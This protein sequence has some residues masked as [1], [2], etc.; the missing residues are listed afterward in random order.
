MASNIPLDCSELVQRWS[1]PPPAKSQ[2]RR[3]RASQFFGR[4]KGVGFS[5]ARSTLKTDLWN[6]RES[7]SLFCASVLDQLELAILNQPDARGI[8]L[9]LPVARLHWCGLLY[10]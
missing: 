5:E 4:G 9:K 6:R 10:F 7:G 1:G 8:V 2:W 3:A